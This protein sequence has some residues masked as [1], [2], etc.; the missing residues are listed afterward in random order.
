MTWNKEHV[1][2]PQE[3]DSCENTDNKTINSFLNAHGLESMSL[4]TTRRWMCLLGFCYDTRKKSFYVDDHECHDVVATQ[5]AFCN[6][7]L[8]ADYEPY[9]RQWVHVSVIEAKSTIGKLCWMLE[10]NFHR[11]GISQGKNSKPLP[12]EMASTFLKTSYKSYM[13]G[14][15]SQKACCKYSGKGG[16][17]RRQC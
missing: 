8:T 2:I 7:Y 16:L 3:A 1:D 15:D 12:T 10:L 4:R 17:L 9:C 5:S 13:D 14:R 6:R 11:S